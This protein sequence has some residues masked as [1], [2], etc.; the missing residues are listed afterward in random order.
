VN[1]LDSL[2]S[3]FSVL[4]GA[5]LADPDD[6]A[7]F[8]AGALLIDEFDDLIALKFETSTKAETTFRRIDDEARKSPR[9]AV[10]I[11]DQTGASLIDDT[12]RA[13]GFAGRKTD[14]SFNHWPTGSDSTPG[15]ISSESKPLTKGAMFQA[16][17]SL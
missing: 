8:G 15:I 10:Q 1:C 2:Q 6:S 3:N 13:A 9:P 7:E 16:T 12:L 17:S 14:R 11:Y 4:F 5:C